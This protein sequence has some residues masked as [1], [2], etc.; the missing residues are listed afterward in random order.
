MVLGTR[1][2]PARL[3]AEV[4]APGLTVPGGGSAIMGSDVGH[5]EVGVVLV[6]VSTGQGRP[7]QVC[8]QWAQVG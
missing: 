4:S 6:D 1:R 3:R 8:E 7:C 2:P 5:A